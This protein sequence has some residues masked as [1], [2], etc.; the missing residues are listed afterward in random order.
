M[1]NNAF[2]IQALTQAFSRQEKDRETVFPLSPKSQHGELEIS[3]DYENYPFMNSQKWICEFMIFS[4]RFWKWKIRCSEKRFIRNVIKACRRSAE[5]E[6]L[7]CKS[8]LR[9]SKA[10]DLAALIAF[11]KTTFLDL[12]GKARRFIQIIVSWEFMK[13]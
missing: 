9:S 13:K 4:R 8:E 11:S 7:T 1:Q 3:L 5:D 6:F 2:R 12:A 10:F